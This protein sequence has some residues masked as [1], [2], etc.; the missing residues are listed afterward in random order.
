MKRLT[1]ITGAVLIVIL[2]LCIASCGKKSQTAAK[3]DVNTASVQQLQKVP[4][5]DR[6]LAQNIVTFRDTNGPFSSVDEL[7][8]VKGMDQQKLSSIRNYV[9]V[10]STSGSQQGAQGGGPGGPMPGSQS[11]SQPKNEP[12]PGGSSRTGS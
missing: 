2:T 7:A 6:T 4:G 3:L 9:T 10:K 5:I 12:G 1:M 11:G 8:R